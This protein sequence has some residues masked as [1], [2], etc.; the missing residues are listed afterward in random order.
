MKIKLVDVAERHLMA[1]SPEY[2]EFSV[3]HDAGMPIPSTR[4]F[5]D[6]QVGVVFQRLQEF[7]MCFLSKL[8]EFS[9]RNFLLRVRIS[10]H[11]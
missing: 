11:I 2:Y 4:L 5:A 7:R 6:D 10:Y 9:F 1:I 3:Q 8:G